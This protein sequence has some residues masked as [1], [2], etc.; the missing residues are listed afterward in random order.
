LPV[1][2]P[3]ESGEFMFTHYLALDANGTHENFYGTF[4]ATEAVVYD[5]DGDEFLEPGDDLSGD[6][7][8]SNGWADSS[9]DQFV[10]AVGSLATLEGVI[11]SVNIADQQFT[12][13][14]ED[15][16][17]TTVELLAFTGLEVLDEDGFVGQTSLGTHLVG[18]QAYIEGSATPGGN[19]AASWVVVHD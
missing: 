8:N 14:H 6:D 9:E 18:M 16:S 4:F 13:R 7:Q 15:G 12:V 10:G 2:A 5:I 11:T 17:T 1:A 19:F 3:G